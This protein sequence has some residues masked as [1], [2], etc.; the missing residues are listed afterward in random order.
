ME[1]NLWQIT[2]LKILKINLTPAN[3]YIYIQNNKVNFKTLLF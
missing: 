3:Y 1:T 2:L